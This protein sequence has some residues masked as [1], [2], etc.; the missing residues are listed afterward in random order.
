VRPDTKAF[1]DCLGKELVERRD[2][3]KKRRGLYI[4][5]ISPELVGGVVLSPREWRHG[6]I[7]IYYYANVFC[8]PVENTLNL[9]WGKKKY[10][11]GESAS[12]AAYCGSLDQ[13]DARQGTPSPEIVN[14]VLSQ[15]DDVVIPKI[16]E[17][18]NVDGMLETIWNTGNVPERVI[19]VR[20][21]SEGMAS[22]KENIS[23]FLAAIEHDDIRARATKFWERLD[24]HG[25]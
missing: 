15:V 9:G 8:L 1:V 19:A 4:F 22:V 12:A 2:L 14:S 10:V 7:D 23:E 17:I 20:I 5:D 24:E 6:P 18:A 13:I 25:W 21:W 3:K 11:V 16:H